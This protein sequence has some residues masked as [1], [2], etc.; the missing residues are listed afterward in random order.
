MDTG[1][2]IS[3]KSNMITNNTVTNNNNNNN[4]ISKTSKYTTFKEMDNMKD[5]SFTSNITVNTTSSTL[6]LN[7]PRAHLLAGLRTTPCSEKKAEH[8][9]ENQKNE[10]A[11]TFLQYAYKKDTINTKQLKISTY[12][13]TAA[14]SPKTTRGLGLPVHKQTT[15]PVNSV[16]EP[17]TPYQSYFDDFKRMGQ[18]KYSPFLFDDSFFSH[19]LSSQQH[20][21]FQKQ[22]KNTVPTTPGASF[23]NVSGYYIPEQNNLSPSIIHKT[24]NEVLTGYTDPIEFQHHP[25]SSPVS[26]CYFQNISQNNFKKNRFNQ[27]SYLNTN[28]S[29]TNL[30]SLTGYHG[31]ISSSNKE[32]APCRQPRGPPSMEKLL[33]P[34]ESEN[35]NFSMRLRKQ[36]INK[37]L[38]AGVQRQNNLLPLASTTNSNNHH[39]L[40]TFSTIS[41]TQTH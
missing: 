29:N 22:T 34:N 18:S 35:T 27:N 15:I 31:H 10:K 38:H 41:N 1:C 30:N 7:T 24:S 39:S 17:S 2:L 28:E 6:P 36:A 40:T 12:P 19:H 5:L 8:D 21:Y 9:Y 25:F 4:N 37:I 33:S 20:S 32:G 14:L 11:S 26:P 23:K 16:S 3:T 13:H